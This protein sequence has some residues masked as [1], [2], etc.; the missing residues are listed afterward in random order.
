MCRASVVTLAILLCVTAARPLTVPL[1]Q[2]EDPLNAAYKYAPFLPD[3][4][5]ELL[6]KAF[7]KSN[8]PAGSD[9][10]SFGGMLVRRGVYG[11]SKDEATELSGLW[12]QAFAGLT[13]ADK[14]SF[15]LIRAKIE[16]KQPLT[17]E[18]VEALAQSTKNA[19]LSLPQEKLGRV[20]ELNHKALVFAVR[21]RWPELIENQPT[22]GL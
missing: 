21:A 18:E 9:I 4:A 10:K 22:T 11:L 6:R 17:A 14:N 16:M 8:S 12:G 7:E 15:A 19:L 3:S 1:P 2:D 20:Q 13:E 5:D